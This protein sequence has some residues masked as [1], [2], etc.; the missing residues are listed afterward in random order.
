MP[1]NFDQPIERRSSGCAK[2]NYY[3][4]DVIPMWV[5]DMDFQA[6][7]PSLQAMHDR[8]EHGVFGY[9]SEVP[10][11]LFLL[12]EFESAREPRR[13]MTLAVV[14][15]ESYTLVTRFIS[16]DATGP[17]SNTNP[18]SCSSRAATDDS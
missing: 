15:R 4:E 2:W 14:S 7:E 1:Y 8:I 6:P 11:R 16:A 18:C 3:D 10:S 12:A 17:G 9:G 5:A 13:P